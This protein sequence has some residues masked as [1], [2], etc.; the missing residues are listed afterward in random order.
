RAAAPPRTR[1]PAR[2]Q[3]RRCGSSANLGQDQG[4]F[5]RIELPPPPDMGYD[6]LPPPPSCRC[7]AGSGSGSPRQRRVARWKNRLL[8][9][10]SRLSPPPG[11]VSTRVTKIRLI[12]TTLPL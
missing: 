4:K 2:G 12:S 6:A 1:R 5:D 7:G 11:W 8:G 3:G 9:T 10:R